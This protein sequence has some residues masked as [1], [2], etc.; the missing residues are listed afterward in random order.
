MPAEV[1]KRAERQHTHGRTRPQ[2]SHPQARL[3]TQTGQAASLGARDAFLVLVAPIQP[4]ETAI[5]FHVGEPAS[6]VAAA[7]VSR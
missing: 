6:I 1:L 5:D 4:S 3:P 7:R 2:G